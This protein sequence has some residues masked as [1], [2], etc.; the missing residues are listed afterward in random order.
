MSLQE[1]LPILAIAGYILGFIGIAIKY[2]V[3]RERINSKN[4]EQDIEMSQ[5]SANINRVQLD[6]NKY[7]NH[8]TKQHEEFYVVKNNVT[9][10]TQDMKYIK[11]ALYEIKKA[12]EDLKK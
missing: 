2:G 10:L 9:E 12:I 8:N 6:L 3:E 1:I 11:E 7:E 4:R 5:L